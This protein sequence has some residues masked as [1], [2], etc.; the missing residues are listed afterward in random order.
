MTM[1]NTVIRPAPGPIV[2]SAADGQ[3]ARCLL[4]LRQFTRFDAAQ[5]IGKPQLAALLADPERPLREFA[6]RPVKLSHTSLVVQAEMQLGDQRVR[7]AYK[8]SQARGWWKQ[9]TS[10]LRS[11][12]AARGWQLG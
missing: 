11:S 12:R 4:P 8:R 3:S 7:V 5:E 9:L 1:G 2:G 6:H 10:S